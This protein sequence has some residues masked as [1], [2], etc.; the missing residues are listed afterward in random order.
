M[1]APALPLITVGITCFNAAATI[2][3]V[4]ESALAQDWS[5]L[6]VVVVDD[7]ST[8]NSL[9]L[10]KEWEA[11]DGRIRIYRHRENQGCAAARNMIIRQAAG[12]F[13]AFFD[14]DDTSSP[15]R[16]RVQHE[17]IVSYENESG[18]ALVACYASGTRYYPNG[19]QMP[20][21]A[22]GS[23]PVVPVGSVLADYLLAFVRQ[24]DVF[25]GSGTPTCSLMARVETFGRIGGFDESFRRQEDADFAVRL[26]FE[27]GHF[28]GTPEPLLQ[29]FAT[30]GSEKSA[31]AEHESL[32]RLLNKNREYLRRKGLYDYML[33]WSEIRFRHFNRQPFLALLALL[34]LGVLHPV[35][36]VQHFIVSGTRRYRHERNIY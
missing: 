36:T 25:Y 1:R 6:E 11:K 3:R 17:R 18:A 27:G 14:D 26:A 30:T 15:D 22:I 33:G 23:R 16:L 35:R 13:I 34:Q 12:A 24:P 19:Y 29:Q 4:L 2:E 9:A 10:L 7:A 28:I 31:W 8:D 32:R 5:N 21:Y 20:I